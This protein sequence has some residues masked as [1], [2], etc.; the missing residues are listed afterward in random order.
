MEL[1]HSADLFPIQPGRRDIVDKF[2]RNFFNDLKECRF[3]YSE[4][5]PVTLAK[6]KE[7]KKLPRSPESQSR[8]G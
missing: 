7:V 6:E 3:Q 5:F 8:M 4:I 2:S 1:R